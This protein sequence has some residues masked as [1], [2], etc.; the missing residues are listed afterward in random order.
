MICFWL[1]NFLRRFNIQDFIFQCTLGLILIYWVS[2][3][4]D[5][6]QTGFHKDGHGREML[7]LRQ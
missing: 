2:N 3:F 6:T 1:E 7:H 5:N 4:F